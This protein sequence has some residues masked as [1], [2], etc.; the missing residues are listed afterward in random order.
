MER[1]ILLFVF[2]QTML[3]SGVCGLDVSFSGG[4]GGVN[5][6]YGC[7]L[8]AD[9]G[10]G[11]L[12]QFSLRESNLAGNFEFNGVGGLNVHE[13]RTNGDGNSVSLMA[14]GQLLP[15]NVYYTDWCDEGKSDPIIG[16]QQLTGTGRNIACMAKAQNRDGLKASVA[17]GVGRGSIDVLQSGTAS[18]DGVD[19]WQKINSASGDNIELYAKTSD[20]L[21]LNMADSIVKVDHGQVENYR[22][23]AEASLVKGGNIDLYAIHGHF[24]IGDDEEK[25]IG[26]ISGTRISSEGLTFNQKGLS[27]LYG[28]TINRGSIEGRFDWGTETTSNDWV[29]A[30]PLESPGVWGGTPGKIDISALKINSYSAAFDAKK[31]LSK[32]WD[33]AKWVNVDDWQE[34]YGFAE[35]S[36]ASKT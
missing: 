9:D 16:V 32:D 14:K 23:E 35:A 21:S 6:D 2:V 17:V 5:R 7:H 34:G 3:I 20:K 29:I 1:R 22:S 33:N 13:T 4:S 11:L 30:V 27:A 26:S 28:V 12:G 10:V 15:G 18:K 24:D 36:V 8:Q 25:S 19:A 31:V